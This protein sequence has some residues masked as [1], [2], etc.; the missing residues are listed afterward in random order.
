ME[1][2]KQSHRKCDT[3]LWQNLLPTLLH[4]NRPNC[5]TFWDT[6]L[7]VGAVPR[8]KKHD[9]TKFKLCHLLKIAMFT[10][11]GNWWSTEVLWKDIYLSVMI[12]PPSQTQALHTLPVYYIACLDLTCLQMPNFVLQLSFGSPEKKPTWPPLKDTYRKSLAFQAPRT[13]FP[14]KQISWKC[15]D[16]VTSAREGFPSWSPLS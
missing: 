1:T 13:R 5:V 10:N 3:G 14:L 8:V 7:F 11:V 9:G 2:K 12:N 4:V 6:T 15:P 16:R